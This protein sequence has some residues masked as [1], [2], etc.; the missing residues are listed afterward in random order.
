M[1]AD[2]LM[3]I[4]Q[5]A[6]MITAFVFMM[7]QIYLSGFVF[8]I[9]NMPQVF[10]WI[11]YAIP[12]RYYITILRGIFLKASSFEALAP[13]LL[14]LT[15]MAVVIFVLAILRFRRDLAPKQKLVE[16]APSLEA[17]A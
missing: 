13:P 16:E 17:A 11:T 14:L 7:P 9:Q 1:V 4:E 6:M 12:L 15:L 10:Q 2:R 8:P 5:Q 3:I